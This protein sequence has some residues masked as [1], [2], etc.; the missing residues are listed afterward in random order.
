[1]KPKEWPAGIEIPT[2]PDGYQWRCLERAPHIRKIAENFDWL[3]IKPPVCARGSTGKLCVVDGQHTAIAAASR[4]VAK[5]PVMI[6]EAPELRHRAQA[7]V[8]HNTDRLNVTPLQLFASRVAAGDKQALAA[9]RVAKAAGVTPCRFQRANRLWQV[10]DTMAVNGLERLVSRYG[11]DRAA[12]VL[13]TLVAA[14][15]APVA[16]HEILA[17][18]ALLFDPSFGWQ[19]STFD[20]VTT[21][22]SKSI[23]IWRRQVLGQIKDGSRMAL[24]KGVAHAWVRAA[25]RKAA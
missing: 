16:V 13:K 4:G 19:H 8:A 2:L 21:I 24:W 3:H 20:L 22:R 17:V 5:I 25:D 15:R 1:M 12:K 18:A 9:Q 11:E 23:D 14:K 7:F 6:V 10:G